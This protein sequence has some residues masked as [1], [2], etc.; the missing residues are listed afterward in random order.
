VT[1][2]AEVVRQEVSE[3]HRFIEP[4]VKSCTEIRA[5]YPV[6]DETSRE[7]FTHIGELG[8]KSLSYLESLPDQ[9]LHDKYPQIAASRRLKLLELKSDWES[10]HEYIRPALDAD[11]L[12]LPMPLISALNGRLR[13]TRKWRS[14]RF[15]LFH[16]VEVNYFEVPS[17]IVR[18]VADGIASQ[19]GG[20]PFPKFLGLI[21]I[22][23]SQADGIFLNCS[24]AH[25]MGHFI[26]QEDVFTLAQGKIDDALERMVSDIGK[27]LEDEEITLC[28]D[29]ISGWTEEMFCDLFAICLIGPAF[30]F[31]LSQLL[32]ASILIESTAGQP[33]DFYLYGQYHPA[34]VARFS[35]HQ[36][37]LEKLGWWQEIQGWPSAPV[38]VLRLCAGS[39]SQFRIEV[40]LP[41]TVPEAKLLHCL[42][43]L[44]NWL[45]KYVPSR[46][47][48]HVDDVTEFHDQSPFIAEY[49]RRA[50][51]PSTI[52][53]RGKTVHPRPVVLINAGYQFLLEKFSLLLEN[54]EGEKPDSIESRSRLSARLELWLLKALEDHR[55]LTGGIS[56]H[57]SIA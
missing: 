57:G 55:L 56:G 48:G 2:S 1:A 52:I 36:R 31:A 40:E 38:E 15:T 33:E 17:G 21:G 9:I 7:F 12:H 53:V 27:P 30:S 22:P 51:V 41:G 42:D 4:L 3:L 43:E 29:L 16:A 49:L 8:R 44:C 24:L 54:I 18:R 28:R 10:L 32:T 34:S 11:T 20:K 37:L 35:V 5:D 6:Y 13:G 14:Y 23:Y 25:E 39:N 50:I 45:I 19:V 26:F 47:K 46:V